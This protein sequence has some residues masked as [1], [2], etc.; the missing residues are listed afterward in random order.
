[1]S[2]A[3]VVTALGSASGADKWVNLS[4]AIKTWLDACPT[5]P[6]ECDI[7]RASQIGNLCPRE[8]VLNY[9]NPAETT[10][11]DWQSMLRMSMGTHLH[12]ILQ[13]EILGPMGV[14]YG[15][16]V[17]QATGEVFTGFYPE[18]LRMFAD[19][20]TPW[21]Y[22]EPVVWDAK[23]RISGHMDGYLDTSRVSWLFDNVSKFKRN[24]LGAITELSKMPLG[25]LVLLEIKTVGSYGYGGLTSAS[26]I[27]DYYKTQAAVYQKLANTP[28]TLFW[29]IERD[30]LNSKTL[31][32]EADASQWAKVVS[33]ARLVWESIRDEVLPTAMMS[34]GS[35]SDIRAKSCSHA[36]MCWSNA[37][38]KEYVAKAKLDQPSR[39]FLDLSGW[40]FDA[41]DAK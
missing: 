35:F 37:S 16:W 7:L 2:L 8:F 1:M 33:K 12:H 30:S 4:K 22:R 21:V 29:F 26:D 36:K 25:S 18:P 34:C 13:N 28:K 20:R 38:F 3:S 32:Y 14:L 11:F 10:S 6:K 31:V 19:G 41:R 9:W 24:P 17:S 27:P 23:Y 40:A 5:S 15:D 39:A